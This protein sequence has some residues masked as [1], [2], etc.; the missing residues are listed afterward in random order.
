M[1]SNDTIFALSS[2]AVPAGVAVF[3]ISG[4]RADAALRAITAHQPLPPPR[5]AML[6]SIYSHAAQQIIDSALIIRFPSPASFT[7]EDVVEIQSHGSPAVVAALHKELCSLPG[8]RPAEAGEFTRRAFESGRIDLTQAEAL[9]DLIVAETEAQR[10]QALSN[11]SGRLRA[12]AEQWRSQILAL[13]ADVEA[14]LDF[15]DEGDVNAVRNHP[16]LS[17]LVR[18]IEAALDTAALGERIRS[19]LTIAIIGPPNAGKSSLL[20]SLARRE[21][22]IVTP[23][24]GTTRDII[25]VHLDLDGVPATIFDTAG[26]HETSDPIEQ[27][28][29]TRARARAATADLVLNMG[30]PE[31]SGFRVVNKID[32]DGQEPGIYDNVAYISATT[33]A[34]LPALEQWLREWARAQIPKGEPALVTQAR[35]EHWLG[36]ALAALQRAGAESDLV[37]HAENLR[38]AAHALGHLTGRIDPEAVLGEIFSRFCIGK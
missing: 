37:L 7:G 2:G 23:I 11:A 13:M 24:A 8:L 35:Q 18:D 21:V 4:P 10:D 5:T 32:L 26:L 25:E 14:D 6:R 1:A 31:M 22:A 9:S 30:N 33:G 3:R 16:S 29:I 12:L 20:N 34:G 27:E 38:S 36:Q 19:G 28:G 15:S 17:V